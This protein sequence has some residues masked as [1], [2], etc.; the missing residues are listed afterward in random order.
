LSSYQHLKN[1]FAEYFSLLIE[2]EVYMQHPF[3]TQYTITQMSSHFKLLH[4]I[5]LC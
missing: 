5:I 3:P 4:V 1:E 2:T